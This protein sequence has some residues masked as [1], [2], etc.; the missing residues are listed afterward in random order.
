MRGS[1]PCPAAEAGA[2]YSSSSSQIRVFRG[3]RG[4]GSG[5]SARS[6]RRMPN[7]HEDEA[8]AP[9]SAT[10][11]RRRPGGDPGSGRARPAAA[12]AA[13]RSRR[14]ALALEQHVARAAPPRAQAAAASARLM[15]ATW[16]GRQLAVPR[17]LA[18]PHPARH[19][20]PARR[21]AGRPAAACWPPG[22][23]RRP[24]RGRRRGPGRRHPDEAPTAPRA[25]A[26]VEGAVADEH[27]PA[28]VPARDGHPG[29]LVLAGRARRRSAPPTGTGRPGSARRAARCAAT[30][31]TWRSYCHQPAGSTARRTARPGRGRPA[32]EVSRAA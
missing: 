6:S 11:G 8:R 17:G 21:G 31:A 27:R 26:A 13:A 4:Y 14:R 25:R 29:P 10:T 22:P 9:W 28:G 32:S 23:T 16:P 3:L 2:A 24:S 19:V 1:S 12:G 20:D 7:Q 30:L 5:S 15:L 18:A